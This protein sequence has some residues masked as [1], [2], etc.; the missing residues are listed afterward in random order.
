LAE[1]SAVSI[2]TISRFENGGADAQLETLFRL[3][4][5]LEAGGVE[6]PD[7][8]TVRLVE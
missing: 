6:F 7:A 4:D 1:K 5:A 8:R 3:Q 2:N